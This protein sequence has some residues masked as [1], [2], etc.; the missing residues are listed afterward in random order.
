MYIKMGRSKIDPETTHPTADSIHQGVNNK[1][2][3]IPLKIM[4][5]YNAAQ[6]RVGPNVIHNWPT[7]LCPE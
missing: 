3:Y 1:L 5:N 6:Y 7:L 4:T 2:L